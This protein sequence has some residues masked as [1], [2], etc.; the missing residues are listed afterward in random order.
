MAVAALAGMLALPVTAEA[1]R[2]I[3]GPCRT[4]FCAGISQDGSRVVFP[5]EEELTAGAGERQIYERS[6]GKT[7]ALLPYE[8]SSEKTGALLPPRGKDW[9]RL[10][11][12]SVDATHV[13]VTTNRPLAPEDTDGLG[14]DLFD[15]SGG[16][17]TLIST[18][19]LDAQSNG[20]AIASFMGIS[21]DGG[22]VFFD[23]FTP[24]TADDADGCPDLY[25]RAAGQTTLVAAD[26]DPPPPPI[27]S[28]TVFGGVSADGFHLFFSSAADLE[29]GDERGEDI[30]QQVGGV[31]TRLTTY[32]EPEGSCVDLVK[33]ADAS[34]D[35]STVLFAT[36][37]PV[38]PEDTD[39]AFDVYKRRPDGTFVLVSR[40]TDGGSGQCGFGGD[41]A[42]ALAADGGVAIFETGARLSPADRDSS[43]DLYSADD[44]GAFELISTGPA[45]ASIDERSSVFPDWPALAS[46]DARRVAF[47][48]H[49][50]LVAADKDTAADVYVR[51]GGATELISAGLPGRKAPGNAELL[52]LSGDGSA[53]VF[54]TAEP[55]VARDLDR[56]R[57]IYLRGSGQERSAL[58]SRETIAPNMQIAKHGA[59]LRSGR[60]AVRLSCPKSETSGPCRGRL[61]LTAGRRGARVGAAS[62]RIAPGRR[63]RVPIRPRARFRAAVPKSAFARARG[64]D[65]LGNA[66][67]V[68]R[69]IRI[70]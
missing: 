43:N 38:T 57:D 34:N 17:A 30:Y 49:Q 15:I 31:L 28:T 26:P 21:P 2:A 55:L 24:M 33:F 37:S 60:I 1:G 59:L 40:G 54:A 19:P 7:R 39:S 14:T 61:V 12:V 18:G 66:R 27:C 64:I 51:A 68:A 11:E 6:A 25:Q 9:P 67:V 10:D 8:R 13:F 22:R 29:P 58:I 44:S 63:V 45:D 46:D 69:K 47:E 32:P 65:A 35:G 62:F 53:V 50:S 41:R 70:G 56:A 4:V 48:T 23:A 5:F 42:L 20:G 16:R 36:N 3:T 52:A